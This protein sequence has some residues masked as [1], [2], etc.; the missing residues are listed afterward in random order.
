[1]MRPA[2]GVE[3][4]LCRQPGASGALLRGWDADFTNFA[5]VID[6][7]PVTGAGS[8]PPEFPG[9]LLP[10]TPPNQRCGA[11]PSTINLRPPRITDRRSVAGPASLHQQRRYAE[12]SWTS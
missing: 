3:V 6:I 1:M 2:D 11:F 8:A 10:P 12:A 7:D 4:Y 9:C 5:V